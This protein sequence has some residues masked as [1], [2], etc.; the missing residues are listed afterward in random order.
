MLSTPPWY[1]APL[2]CRLDVSRLDTSVP[3][4]VGNNPGGSLD[5][6]LDLYI[7]SARER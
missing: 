5:R 2:G 3:E 1:L 7:A 4:R 6:D